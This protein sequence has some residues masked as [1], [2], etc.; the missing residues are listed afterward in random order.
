MR[1]AHKLSIVQM[2][3]IA[4]VL[5]A[6]AVVQF[7]R[8]VNLFESDMRRDQVVTAHA[9]GAAVADT[10]ERLGKDRALRLLD[11]ARASERSVDIRWVWLEGPDAIP[12][13][14]AGNGWTSSSTDAPPRVRVHRGGHG[15]GTLETFLP[16]HIAGFPL[17]A[18][19]I[20]ESL[21]EERRFVRS[22]ILHLI[23]T[24][25]LIGLGAAAISVMFGSSIIVK[26]M[27]LLVAQARRVGAG[28]LSRRLPVAH[29]DEIGELAAEMN[30]MCALL[31][32]SSTRLARE[33]N[34]RISALEQLRHADRLATVGTLSS[35]IAHEL[36]TP[37]NVVSGRAKLI[38]MGALAGEAVSDSARIIREQ[39]ERMAT[40]IRQLLDFSR[41]GGHERVATPLRPAAE[42]VMVMLRPMAEKRGVNLKLEEDPAGTHRA[43]IDIGQIHQVLANLMMNGIQSMARGGTLTIR[44]LD[45]RIA[46]PGAPESDE[47]AFVVVEVEDEGCGVAEDILPRIFDPFFTTKEVGEGT[48]LGL[49]VSHGIIQEHGGWID[50]T[51]TVG[52]GS[53]FRVCLPG[54]EE[55]CA[56]ES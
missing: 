36:G 32:E 41:R 56:D 8:E 43:L 2:A 51:S 7:R 44:I 26:P 18:V 35:G 39:T 10:W 19:R 15:P 53:R 23:G 37:L 14:P 17:G 13:P 16:V 22:T 42:K 29:H 1:L 4:A 25:T 27:R 48:G 5:L 33:T 11:E 24:M 49:S 46:V 28:D 31:E 52:R 12:D 34:A 21:G 3:V 54:L 40:I 38:E 30:Q 47:R 9:L 6:L 55:P 45:R 50:V 20:S